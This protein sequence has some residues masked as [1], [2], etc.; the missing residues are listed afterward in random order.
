MTSKMGRP[1]KN[2][3]THRLEIRLSETENQLLKDCTDITGLTR[4]DVIIKGLNLL[5]EQLNK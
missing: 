3:K 4:T 1:T 2:P 5:K